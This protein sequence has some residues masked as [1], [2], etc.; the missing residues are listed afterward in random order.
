MIYFIQAGNKAVKIGWSESLKNRMVDLQVANYE[1]LKV[2]YSFKGGRRLEKEL[3]N[4]AK[5]YYIRGEWFDIKVLQDTKIINMVNDYKKIKR[6]SVITKYIGLNLKPRKQQ[7]AYMINE[8][9]KKGMT[10]ATIG[11]KIHRHYIT[12]CRYRDIKIKRPHRLVLPAL[13][14]IKL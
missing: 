9:H 14:R 10:Y 7:I 6:E 5:K 1:K 4:M 11:K 12:V 8:L 13:K 2:I 3:Q